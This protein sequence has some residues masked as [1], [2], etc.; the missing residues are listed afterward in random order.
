MKS[1]KPTSAPETNWLWGAV[2]LVLILFFFFWRSFLPGYVH[3]NNDG[4]LGAMKTAS[5]Q[6]PG[7][8]TGAWASQNSIGS[9]GAYPLC[10]SGLIFWALGPVGVGKF[11]APIALL[12]L[13]L[14]ALTLFRQLRLAPVAAILGGLAAMLNTAFFTTACWGVASQQIAAGMDFFAL[15]LIVSIRQPM[16]PAI[17]WMRIALAGLAVGMNFTEAADIG[18]LYSVCVAAFTL[19]L[20]LSGELPSLTRTERMVMLCGV[21]LAFLLLLAG[22][23]W[24][25]LG[26]KLS[27]VVLVA[28]AAWNGIMFVDRAP[29][30]RLA[31]GAGRLMV[32]VGC[33]VFI[34]AQ[35]M[36][37]TIELQIKGV[38]GTQQDKESKADRWEFATQWSFPKIE[39]L[40]LFVPG[41]FGYRL[42]PQSVDGGAPLRDGSDYWGSI[43]RHEAWDQYF[44][45][46]KQGTPP[47]N[48]L[49]RH[50]GGGNY[51]GVFV[52]LVALWAALQSFRGKDSVF[53]SSE[54]KLVWFWVATIG[55]CLLLAFGRYAPVYRF[56]YM[57]PYISAMRSP[58]KY[59]Y[60]LNFAVVILFAYGIHGLSRRYLETSLVNVSGLNARL[61]NWWAKAATFDRKWVIGCV[62]AIVVSLLGWLIYSSFRPAL[63]RHLETVPTMGGSSPAAVASF[64]VQQLGWFVLFLAASVGVVTLILIGS[65]AG[66]R[67]RWA[68]ILLGLVLVADLWQVD[69]HFVVFWNYAEKYEIGGPNPIIQVLAKNPYEHRVAAL[70]RWFPY[71]FRKPQDILEAQQTF[72]QLYSGEWAQHLFLYYNVQSLDII[73][74]PRTP[75]DLAAFEGA[76]LFRGTQDTLYLVARRWE[77]TN[78]RFLLGASDWLDVLNGAL[79]PAQQRFRILERFNIRLRPGITSYTQPEDITAV[80]DANGVLA[81]FEFAGALPR[82]KLYSNWQVSTN[83]QATLRELAGKSFAP[84]QTVLVANPGPAAPTPAGAT[85]QNS[86]SVEFLDYTPKQIVL[87]TKSAAPSILLLNDKYDPNWRVSVDGKPAELL[88]CNFIMRGVRLDPGSHTVDFRFSM[89][90]GP[91]YVT[92]AATVIG[93]LLT[94]LVLILNFKSRPGSEGQKTG[95]D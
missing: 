58:T 5:T 89:F 48:Q 14:G 94:G 85:N 52:V 64:S 91:L 20:A 32:I 16:P 66:R 21:N 42:V 95:P 24:A 59:L 72:D 69:R 54:R 2:L 27:C 77:L 34:T 82:A 9:P 83:D 93:A 56:V 61:K 53:T 46:G 80:P 4:P 74:M 44:E 78:T 36:T 41:L 13:G 79:D 30:N 49:L 51:A 62:V 7:E 67:A 10:V 75:E 6:F 11:F 81:I 8:F 71:A 50:V 68:G 1:A 57:V 84:E 39:T 86:G 40:S 29:A 90:T 55:V 22:I 26:I 23:L 65:L 19:Y 43:G 25:G 87:K 12:I 15:A 33:A 76:L 37:G 17:R 28:M 70:P 47:T 35:S 60:V 31:C 63:E 45:S 3:F 92:L 18:A 88:R 73:Q 38:V